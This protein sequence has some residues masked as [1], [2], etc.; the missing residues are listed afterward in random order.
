LRTLQ[1]LIRSGLMSEA[2]ILSALSAISSMTAPAPR[3]GST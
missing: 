1:T 3:K 2:R